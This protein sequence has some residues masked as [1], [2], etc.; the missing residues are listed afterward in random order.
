MLNFQDFR[1]LSYQILHYANRGFL[2]VDFLREIVKLIVDFSGCDAVVLHIKDRDKYYHCT[3]T[4][5]AAP[6]FTID[7]TPYTENDTIIPPFQGNSGL[8]R[9]RREVLLGDFDPASPFFTK[10]GSFWTNDSENPIEG[11]DQ[12]PAQSLCTDSECRSL[13]LI[14]IVTHGERHEKIGL[15]ELKS[16]QRDFFRRDEID[17]YEGIA[18]MISVALAHRRAQVRLRERVKELTCLYGIAQ[19]AER[20]NVTLDQ[21]LQSIVEL[22][23]PAWLHPDIAVARIIVDGHAYTTAGF[24]SGKH[25]QAAEIAVHGDPRGVIEVV[26]TEEKPELDEGPF[27]KEERSLIETIAKELALIIERKKAEE[28]KTKLEEQLRHADRLATIGQLAA[29][30]AHELNEPLGS[31]LGFAQ[32]ARKNPQLPQ[33]AEQDLEKIVTSSLQAREIIK[34]LLIFARQMP[35]SKTLVNLNQI[36]NDGLS[37]LDSRLAKR[38]IELALLLAP[39]LPE[40]TA[41]PVQLHQVLVN[42][43]VNAVQAMPNSG[44]LTI[45]TLAGEGRVSLIV[46]DTGIGM[47]EEVLQQI[48]VP[49]FSTKD[50]GEGTGLGLAVVHGIVKSHGGFIKVESAPERGSRFEVQLPV[51]E[52]PLTDTI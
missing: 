52:A 22:L 41:D 46:E 2:R 18:E 51:T 5:R 1:A 8:N 24:Q 26:Y 23:P 48:F 15:L 25:K 17:F 43:I 47:S 13:A 20:P 30:L 37:L 35:P 39:S 29:G 40:I 50:V 34:K 19:I 21:M 7:T 12:L 6:S 31:I 36:V 3:F 38:E 33:E 28:D 27:L 10:N 44:R 45:Q 9:L 16:A 14:P 49:F 42:L 11:K 4:P 32:L